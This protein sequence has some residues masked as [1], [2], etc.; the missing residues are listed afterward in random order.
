MEL[1]F[2]TNFFFLFIKNYNNIILRFTKKF[3]INCASNNI[4]QNKLYL[5]PEM[6]E[7]N[8]ILFYQ[9][10]CESLLTSPSAKRI[11]SFLKNT[12]VMKPIAIISKANTQT[13]YLKENFIKT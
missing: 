4:S 8:F 9:E 3:A 11:P 12:C 1:R 7:T 10:Q 13:A 2:K 6:L 5:N